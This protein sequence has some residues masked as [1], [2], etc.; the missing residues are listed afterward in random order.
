MPST[1]LL[2]DEVYIH[3]PCVSLEFLQLKFD[4]SDISDILLHSQMSQSGENRS[5]GRKNTKTNLQLCCISVRNEM[6]IATL[7]PG[8]QS[9]FIWD[10]S[11]KLGWMW[12]QE[13]VW[14]S[15]YSYF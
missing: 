15:I 10:K 12:G 3:R 5:I 11:K 14:A 4:I 1:R 6:T 13:K 9:L 7:F 2:V 8:K